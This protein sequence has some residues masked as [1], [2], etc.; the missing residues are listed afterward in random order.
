M[1]SPCLIYSFELKHSDNIQKH[2]SHFDTANQFCFLGNI[3]VPP[4]VAL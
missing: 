1:D 2:K 4:T 3:E